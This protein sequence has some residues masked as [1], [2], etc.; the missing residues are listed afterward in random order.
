MSNDVPFKAQRVTRTATLTLPAPREQAFPLFGPIREAEWA[1]GW[2]PTMIFSETPLGEEAGAVFTTRQPDEPDTIW[3]ITQFD[4][5]AFIIEYARVTPGVRTALVTIRCEAA[6]D[7]THASVTYQFTALSEV[8]NSFVKGFSEI[9]YRHMMDAW[10]A[11]I[12]HTLN[13]GKRLPH[14]P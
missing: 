9:H 14:H 8:G 1:E 2:E 10:Q 4:P 3:L 5:A 12:S 6:G 13:T 11:A 7:V